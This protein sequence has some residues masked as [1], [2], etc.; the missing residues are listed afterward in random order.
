MNSINSSQQAVQSAVGLK[1]KNAVSSLENL[2]VEFEG[3]QGILVSAQSDEGK[4]AILVEQMSADKLP[5]QP[6]AVCSVD[7]SW[8]SQSTLA[9]ATVKE[10]ALRLELSP[11]G[12]VTVSVQFWQGKPF[13]AFQPY[14]PAK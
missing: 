7:W 6:D 9:A 1:V 8:I 3:G 4:P 10:G 13:L 14:K 11:A 2:S 5:R 12:T